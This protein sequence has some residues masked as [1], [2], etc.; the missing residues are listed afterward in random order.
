MPT[1]SFKR[2]SFHPSI[3]IVLND[4]LECFVRVENL[5]SASKVAQALENNGCINPN[6]HDHSYSLAS[7]VIGF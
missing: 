1:N 5:N 4:V 6:Q 7:L 2:N 3:R